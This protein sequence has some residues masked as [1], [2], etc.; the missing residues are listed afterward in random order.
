MTTITILIVSAIASVFLMFGSVLAL[1]DAYSQRAPR[2][3]Q[4]SDRKAPVA[5]NAASEHRKAA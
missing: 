1:C 3:M 4:A 5:G 2:D